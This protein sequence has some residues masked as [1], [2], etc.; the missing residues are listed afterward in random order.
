MVFF[1]G[2]T[3]LRKNAIRLLYLMVFHPLWLKVKINKQQATAWRT[4]RVISML[5][6]DFCTETFV[7]LIP[8]QQQ[9]VKMALRQDL[10]LSDEQKDFI[11]AMFNMEGKMGGHR[12]TLSQVAMNFVMSK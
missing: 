11:T 6:P 8:Y 2:S 12:E 1:C 4:K 7:M 9:L 10:V 5:V 3:V